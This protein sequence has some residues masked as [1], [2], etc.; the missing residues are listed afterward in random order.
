LGFGFSDKPTNIDYA[1]ALQ[2]DILLALLKELK[3]N[4]IHILAQDY[5]DHIAQE[6]LARNLENPSNSVPKISSVSLLNGGLFPETH[7]PTS[8]QKLFKSPI[9]GFVSSLL[10]FNL[11]KKRFAAVFGEN[12]SPSNQELMD[13]WYIIYLKNGHQINHKLS[14]A[15]DDCVANRTRWVNGLNT[16]DIPIQFINGQSDP[17]S[18]KETADRYKELVKNANVIRLENIGHYP[19]LECPDLVNSHL[20]SFID[21]L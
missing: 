20:R 3:I 8:I 5:G 1:T 10:N 21:Q 16:G 19:Q 15:T 6:L 9:G 18:G 2:T 12:T 13:L 11:F 14:Y 17:V 4:D 7:Q